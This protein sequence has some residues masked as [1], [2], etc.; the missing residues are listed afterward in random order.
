MYFAWQYDTINTMASGL[1]DQL[2]VEFYDSLRYETE[3]VGAVAAIMNGPT[4]DVWFGASSNLNARLAKSGID[5]PRRQLEI[6]FNQNAPISFNGNL[7]TQLVHHMEDA[8]TRRHASSAFSC[9]E[10]AAFL[11]ARQAYPRDDP[12]QYTIVAQAAT[13]VAAANNTILAPCLSCKTMLN[14]L[15]INWLERSLNQE[16][17]LW[18]LLPGPMIENLLPTWMRLIYRNVD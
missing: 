18:S 16:A 5:Q 2:R 11:E 4:G 10:V 1:L 17:V 8:C 12:A 7:G 13:D 9:A 14:G 6:H 15:G 3:L